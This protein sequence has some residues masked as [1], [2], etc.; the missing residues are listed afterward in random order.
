MAKIQIHE[1]TVER[2]LADKGI[3][4]TTSFTDK[5]G[6]PRK[7]KFTVWGQPAGISVGA[8]VNVTGNMSAR[9]DEF[10]GDNGLV[11][12]ASVHVNNPKIETAASEDMPF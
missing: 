3:F 8:I 2:L 7:E 9:V 6:T 11:R 10:E 12:Y 5:E 4:V 1:A